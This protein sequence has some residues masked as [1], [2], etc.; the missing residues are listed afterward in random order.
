MC[1]CEIGKETS[2]PAQP[3]K[4]IVLDL[5]QQG[6]RDEEALLQELNETERTAI[7]TWERWSAKD[8]VAHRTFWH[9]DLIGKVTAILQQQ[10]VSPNEE[11]D[12]QINTRVFEEH[13]LRPWSALHAESERVYAELIQVTEH[14]SEEEL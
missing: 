3:L 2:M 14:L 8:H 13:Q 4:T 1:R 5:L 6:H 9:Q 7:G 10:E 11:S 12:D